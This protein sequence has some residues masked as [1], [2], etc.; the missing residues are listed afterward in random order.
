M[1]KILIII[2]TIITV[3]LI[4]TLLTIHSYNKNKIEITLNKQEIEVYENI[5]LKDIINENINMLNNQKINTETIGKQELE[6]QYKNKIFKYKENIEINIVDTEKPV[7]LVGNK[8]VEEATEIDLVNSFLCADNYDS[9]PNCEIEGNYDINTPGEYKLKYIA[10]DSSNNKTEKQF[11]L[12]VYEKKEKPNTKEPQEESFVD[13]QDIIKIHKNEKTKIGIDVSKWQGN[14]DF[15]KVKNAGCE[16]VIIKA[17]GSYIDGE[18]YTDPK[19]IE[20][21]ENA[22]KNNLKVGVY[23][24]SD[25]NSVEMA[26]QEIDYTLNL[27]KDYNIELGIAYDWENF[28]NFNTFNISI[29]TLNEM[30]KIFLEEAKTNNY[31]PVLYSS[32]YYLENIWKKDYPI[33]VAQYAD[34]NTYEGDYIMWQQCSDG[35]IDGINGYVDIDIMYE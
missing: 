20:N 26:K 31:K 32:K 27:I 12:T 7:I 34:N 18:M 14:I 21:I 13:F 5:E 35:K 2:I 17:A 22:L 30:S 6:I 8:W 24:N 33:W 29:H 16:F 10:T 9:R 3:V 28:T 23:F 11:T 1:K 15:E 19:F 25:A 4:T